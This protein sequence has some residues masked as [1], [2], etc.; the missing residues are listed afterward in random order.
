MQGMHASRN[1]RV[2][3]SP[4]IKGMLSILFVIENKFNKDRV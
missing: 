3:H 4:I 2:V 1:L